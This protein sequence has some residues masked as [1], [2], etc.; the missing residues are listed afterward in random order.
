MTNAFISN[1]AMSEER[2]NPSDHP[3]EKEFRRDQLIGD[4]TSLAFGVIEM[5]VG[6]AL[7]VMEVVTVGGSP[8][9]PSLF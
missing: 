9:F 1:M 8:T 4:G 2:Q 5:F 6:S 7:P 3:E